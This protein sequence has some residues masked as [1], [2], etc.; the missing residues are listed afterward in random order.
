MAFLRIVSALF[1]A[2]MPVHD[3]E[4]D[5]VGQREEA[6]GAHRV[7][8]GRHGDHGVGGIEIAA[9]EEPRDPRAEVAPAQ[10]PFVE[11]L[12]LARAARLPARRHEAIHR[13]EDEE[14]DE[15]PQG[16][17]VDRGR[18]RWSPFFCSWR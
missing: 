2:K 14:A 10:A 13:E 16:G 5:R 17:L 6:V 12:A 18:H 11:V 15:D 7:D 1:A 3:D 8:E 9:D 4:D